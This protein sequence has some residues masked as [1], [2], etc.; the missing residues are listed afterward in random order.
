MLLPVRGGAAA[1]VGEFSPRGEMRCSSDRGLRLRG[2]GSVKYFFGEKSGID[3]GVTRLMILAPSGVDAR[4]AAHRIGPFVRNWVRIG[5]SWPENLIPTV[6]KFI[7]SVSKTSNDALPAAVDTSRS[8]VGAPTSRRRRIGLRPDLPPTGSTLRRWK[9]LER[10]IFR[11]Y[12]HTWNGAG[13]A[14]RLRC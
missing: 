11:R 10:N 12:A 14:Q 1:L 13:Q 4:G 9:V 7:S 2:R 6:G 3:T 5:R 8:G